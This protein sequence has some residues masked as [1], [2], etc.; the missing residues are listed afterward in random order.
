MTD[1]M[2]AVLAA[3][4]TPALALL[5][6]QLH[7]NGRTHSCEMQVHLRKIKEGDRCLPA[8]ASSRASIKSF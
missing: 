2:L 4:R 3:T 6:V 1:V 5:Q 8:C 7:S